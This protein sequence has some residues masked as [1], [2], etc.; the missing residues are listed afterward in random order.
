MSER[1][2]AEINHTAFYQHETLTLNEDMVGYMQRALSELTLL[3]D[4]QSISPFIADVL[5][6]AA[7]ME[8]EA[9]RQTMCSLK[10]V[11]PRQL[12]DLDNNPSQSRQLP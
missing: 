10:H 5:H 12:P 4:V 7:D 3:E 11:Q 8:N 6:T 9:K 2:A 1:T